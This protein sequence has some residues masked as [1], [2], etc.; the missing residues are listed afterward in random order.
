MLEQI[1]AD[2]V[3]GLGFIALWIGAGGTG[4]LAIRLLTTRHRRLCRASWR[5]LALCGLASSGALVFYIIMG[6]LA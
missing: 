1:A 4:Y 3:Q 6:W 2:T 5:E